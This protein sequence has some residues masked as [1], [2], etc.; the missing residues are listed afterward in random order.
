MS[1]VMGKP[2]IAV[3]E[4]QMGRS[5][6]ASAQKNT[7]SFF[8]RNFKPLASLSGCAGRFL[9][10][11]VANPEDRFSR[12]EAQIVVMKTV[13]FRKA[14]FKYLANFWAL[15]L[16]YYHRLYEPRHEKT[17]LCDQVRHKPTCAAT[18]AR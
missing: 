7:S 17:C 15:C 14:I 8:I 9:S 11:L 16:S 6:C 4:Q 18:E 10:Y 5:A 3:C 12:D 1:H 13:P 2:V